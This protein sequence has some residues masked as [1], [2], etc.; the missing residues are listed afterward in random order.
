MFQPE[1]QILTGFDPG[2]HDVAVQGNTWNDA[3]QHR[4]KS[5]ARLADELNIFEPLLS[6]LDMILESHDCILGI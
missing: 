2:I 5:R 3:I 6:F 1:F 4:V